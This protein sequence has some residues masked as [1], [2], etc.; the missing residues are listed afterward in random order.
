MSHSNSS[1]NT[2]T[3]CQRKYWHNYINHT[4]PDVPPSPHLTFGTMAHEV[5]CKAGEL[6][7]LQGVVPPDEYMTVIP[8]ELIYTDLKDFFGIKN[9][10]HYF[11]YV[12]LE[13]ARIEK[14]LIEMLKNESGK[15]VGIER[16]V[17]LQLPPDALLKGERYNKFRPKQNL[18]GVIDLLLVSGD[19]AI[20]I[21][22]KFSKEP[23]TQDNFDLD[24][25]LYI[26][27]LFVN[28]LYGVPLRNIRVGYIDIP[29]SSFDSP[30]ILKNGTLS[31]SK[32]Q[33]VSAEIYRLAVKAVHGDDDY[34]N[35]DEGG[36]YADV[37]KELALKK[38]AYLS[39]Q[40]VD[41]DA[42]QYIILDI[43]QTMH[44]I[45]NYNVPN[46]IYLAK[47]DAYSC[48]SCEYRSSCKHW[49]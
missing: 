38:A 28:R 36:Y 48:G 14:Q 47:Y 21:D 40:Y 37:I 10:H 32:S 18:V 5:L 35:C 19:H 24:S 16:E 25:Q 22:Y 12:I 6:R 4:I 26:Y 46:D 45:D 34:Y 44:T 31:R 23:K 20:I 29:K 11:H 49:S 42:L 3:Y 8:S 41:T 27:A 13:T 7:D 43:M 39:L 1:L 2:F 17:K 33:N 30:L 9:W 15:P